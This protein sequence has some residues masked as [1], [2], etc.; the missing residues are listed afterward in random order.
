MIDKGSNV[1]LTMLLDMYSLEEPNYIKGENFL[2]YCPY[3]DVFNTEYY[4][5]QGCILNLNNSTFIGGGV[6]KR[7]FNMGIYDSHLTKRNFY[8]YN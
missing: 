4:D 7:L 6:R 5:V 3:H 2:D 8:K 1:L